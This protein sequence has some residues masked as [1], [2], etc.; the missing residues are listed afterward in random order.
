MLLSVDKIEEERETFFRE[1]PAALHCMSSLDSAA[2]ETVAR[3][4]PQQRTGRDLWLVQVTCA[5]C[6]AWA[7]CC[8]NKPLFP[9]PVAIPFLQHF[10]PKANIHTFALVPV[11]NGMLPFM[12]FLRGCSPNGSRDWQISKDYLMILPVIPNQEKAFFNMTVVKYSCEDKRGGIPANHRTQ[13][14]SLC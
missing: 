6:M 3:S 13:C 1:L 7:E 11:M 4:Q 12:I 2:M 9:L 14:S 5:R 10:S 8:K